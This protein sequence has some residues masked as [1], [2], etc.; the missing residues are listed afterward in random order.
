MPFHWSYLPGL[1]A[2]GRIPRLGQRATLQHGPLGSTEVLRPRSSGFPRV[3]MA[4]D[5]NSKSSLGSG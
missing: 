1:P 4:G 2:L 3:G 5:Q